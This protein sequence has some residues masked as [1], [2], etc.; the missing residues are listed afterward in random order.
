MTKQSQ[1]AAKKVP[2][3]IY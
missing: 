1:L 3:T 2:L